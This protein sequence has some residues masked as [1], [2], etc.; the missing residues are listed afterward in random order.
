MEA[1]EE[2]NLARQLCCSLQLDYAA[3]SKSPSDASKNYDIT[4]KLLQDVLAKAA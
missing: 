3:R 2:L 1:V 4:V